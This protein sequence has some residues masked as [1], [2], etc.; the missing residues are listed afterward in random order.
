MWKRLTNQVTR[1]VKQRKRSI[2][3]QVSIT[4][5]WDAR[6][7]KKNEGRFWQIEQFEKR[8]GKRTIFER[9]RNRLKRLCY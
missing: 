3:R 2:T 4:K 6:D 9:W 1:I 8:I 7:T 5:R